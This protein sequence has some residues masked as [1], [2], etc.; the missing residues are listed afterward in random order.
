MVGKTPGAGAR[1]CP[2]IPSSGTAFG[3]APE[4]YVNDQETERTF[5]APCTKGCKGL[6]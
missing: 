3:Q 5:V 2:A 1:L 6:T 4:C